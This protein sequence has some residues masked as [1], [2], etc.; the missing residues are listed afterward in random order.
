MC[1]CIS[2]HILFLVVDCFLH[3]VLYVCSI[4]VYSLCIPSYTFVYRLLYV[5]TYVLIKLYWI[6]ILCTVVCYREFFPIACLYICIV[7]LC[8][9]EYSNILDVLYSNCFYGSNWCSC[10]CSVNCSMD[11]YSNNFF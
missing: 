9:C 2:F 8:F 3:I 7:F 6:L 4:R 5:S 10:H 11:I 1:F